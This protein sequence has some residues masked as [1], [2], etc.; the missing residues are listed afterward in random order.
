MIDN[1]KITIVTIC[2]NNVKEIRSTIE[3]VIN[4]TYN[5]IE[6]LIVDG[7]S[8]D[9]SVGVIN[10]YLDKIDRFLS[11]PD[12]NMYDAINKGLKMAT[13]EIVGLIHAGDRL[14]DNRVVE[15]IASHFES[16]E[17]DVM[18]GHSY[19]VNEHD[20]PVR[21]NRS[22]EYRR[23]LAK[24]GWMPSHQSIYIRRALLEK[25]GY[26]NIELHPS[27]DYEFF[28]RYFHFN[29][30]RIKRLNEYIVRFAMGGMS[31]KN[32]VNNLKAQKKQVMCWE[33]NGETPPFYMVPLKLIRKVKQFLL[34][35][36]FRVIKRY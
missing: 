31:T 20:V 16:N 3:S 32:Y 22:P 4:Q 10:E 21:I 12:K 5:N 8:S 9:G 30:L 36:I 17:I 6:Y 7:D 11:E 29:R 24:I 27:A 2:Y 35:A 23:N 1:P 26:Y 14:F 18:Y 34:A 28:L 15:K 33:I 13:G 19:L 25:Y